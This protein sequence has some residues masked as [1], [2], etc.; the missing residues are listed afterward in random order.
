[1]GYTA[2]V[3]SVVNIA[4]TGIVS[5]L[6]VGLTFGLH[7][8]RSEFHYTFIYIGSYDMYMCMYIYDIAAFCTKLKPCYK[9]IIIISVYYYWLCL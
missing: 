9:H 7:C 6:I 4:Y 1:M 2:V 3:L 5:I 8:D